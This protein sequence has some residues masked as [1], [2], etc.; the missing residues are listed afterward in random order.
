MKYWP[1]GLTLRVVIPWYGFKQAPLWWLLREL[2]SLRITAKTLARY[3][4]DNWHQV[5]SFSPW[6][7]EF[8]FLVSGP[9]TCA[10]RSPMDEKHRKLFGTAYQG[11]PGDSNVYEIHFWDATGG[12]AVYKETFIGDRLK[13]IPE[14][15]LGRLEASLEAFAKGSLACSDCG[16]TLPLSAMPGHYFAGR[17]CG[18]CWL[19]E[20]G[21]RKGTGGWKAVEARENYE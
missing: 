8:S 15:T 19:G 3:Q 13:P 1:E 16:E 11:G 18:P 20:R 6:P 12:I 10:Y 21:E 2:N 7:A 17:Y 9:L 14:T 4:Y 5:V